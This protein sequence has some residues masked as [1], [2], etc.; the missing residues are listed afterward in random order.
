MDRKDIFE[1]IERF[2]TSS[3]SSLSIKD[4]DFSIEMERRSNATEENNAAA[5]ASPKPAVQEDQVETEKGLQI[6]APLVGT[7]YV[8]P[9]PEE[10]PFVE[11]G[12]KVSRGQTLCIIEA[13]KMLNELKAPADGVITA[14][15]GKN[16]ELVQFE[17]LLF[18]VEQC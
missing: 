15:Y 6:T 9:G 5:T 3:L 13:M 11:V 14:I 2:E 12:Q 16:G 10:K 7:Y 1:I 18:E 4:R 8:A 17:Q